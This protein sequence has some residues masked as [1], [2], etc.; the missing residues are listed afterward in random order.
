[1]TA[2]EYLEQIE[3]IDIR[4]RSLEKQRNH[5]RSKEG[6]EKSLQELRK[7]IDDLREESVQLQKKITVEIY[8][9]KNNIYSGLLAEKYLCGATWECIAVDLGYNSVKYVREVVF[10]KA[11]AEFEKIL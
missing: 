3:N 9:M 8:S 7:L 2:K 4:L 10:P 6:N 5:L 11:L 1:M